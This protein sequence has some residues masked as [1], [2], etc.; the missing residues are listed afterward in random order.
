MGIV[1]ALTVAETARV[2]AYSSDADPAERARV[3]EAPKVNELKAVVATA[4]KLYRK[5]E[6]ATSASVYDYLVIA[7]GRPVLVSS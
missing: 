3:E 5:Q 4:T 7:T 1:D 2:A 6:V